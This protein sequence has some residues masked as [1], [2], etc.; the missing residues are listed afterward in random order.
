[1]EH[2]LIH[3]LGLAINAILKRYRR[4]RTEEA[5]EEFKRLLGTDPPPY[6]R[7]LVTG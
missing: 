7:K 5:G 1:M 4:Q 3:N 2:A 6:T